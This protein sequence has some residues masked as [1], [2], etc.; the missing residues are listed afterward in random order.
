MIAGLLE[1]AFPA[2][3]ASCGRWGS[4]PLCDGCAARVRWISDPVCDRCG[5]PA[6]APARRATALPDRLTAGAPGVCGSCAAHPPTFRRARAPAVY[7]GPARDAL[8]RFK[9]AGERRAARGLAEAMLEVSGALEADAVCF[10]PSTRRGLRERGFNPA[11][12]LAR[13]VARGRG[14][15]LAPLLR[16]RRETADQAGLPA[17]ARRRNLLDAFDSRAAPARVLLVDDVITTG[18]T[19]GACTSALLR[20]GARQVDVLAFARAL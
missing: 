18:A 16:K 4:L 1:I 19:A 9:L 11:E 10:V 5:R 15:P 12:A 3:C 2:R 6:A 17:D 7:A 13:R 20:A 8:I 14:L